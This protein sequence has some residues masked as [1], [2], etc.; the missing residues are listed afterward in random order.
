[1][2]GI[3]SDMICKVIGEFNNY[4]HSSDDTDYQR[5]LKFEDFMKGTGSSEDTEMSRVA[6]VE[7]SE[8]DRDIELE[9][10]KE[11][12]LKGDGGTSAGVSRMFR[13]MLEDY[14]PG[15]FFKWEDYAKKLSDNFYRM[16]YAQFEDLLPKILTEKLKD[17]NIDRS[18]GAIDTNPE[19]INK[20]IMDS[21]I[22]LHENPEVLK[23]GLI[24][25][26][27]R[28]E[29]EETKGVGIADAFFV[30]RIDEG[31]L[32]ERLKGEGDEDIK[33]GDTDDEVLS[34]LKDR[35]DI[36][37]KWRGIDEY[38]ILRFTL[39]DLYGS[40]EFTVKLPGEIQTIKPG[41]Y[42]FRIK[43]VINGRG[44]I[45]E[46]K[47]QHD[48]IQ[49]N[50]LGSIAED[51]LGEDQLRKFINNGIINK[52]RSFLRAQPAERLVEDYLGTFSIGGNQ[53]TSVE[54][55]SELSGYGE[56]DTE[57]GSK[58]RGKEKVRGKYDESVERE[59]EKLRAMLQR[60]ERAPEIAKHFMKMSEADGSHIAQ[61]ISSKFP[62]ISSK[63]VPSIDSILA[64]SP[65]VEMVL[66]YI[67]SPHMPITGGGKSSPWI[68]FAIDAFH[69]MALKE[70]SV[71]QGMT[72]M[73]R[74]KRKDKI[75]GMPVSDEEILGIL[76]GKE[77]VLR[78]AF[79]NLVGKIRGVITASKGAPEL[80]KFFERRET[81]Q[82]YIRGQ[83]EEAVGEFI[84]NE[85][86]SLD[87]P[88]D[89]K[90][91]EQ[92]TK[93]YIDGAVKRMSKSAG[94]SS[95]IHELMIRMSV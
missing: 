83:V 91:I 43:K 52:Y 23:D 73:I 2:R 74:S 35:E 31:T 49:G 79:N 86:L 10:S 18:E 71:R 77:T 87:N 64:T 45:I 29:D 12:K 58:A 61:V 25:A 84:K 28:R 22:Y 36:R 65:V 7:D 59:R 81:F 55:L 38:G 34:S 42:T 70:T 8:K 66:R 32:A 37:W 76:S 53:I 33:I 39:P 94:Q 72:Q 57:K 78:N 60:W 89:T 51:G 92:F 85:G 82:A 48:S 26:Y 24:R 80:K 46:F 14:L 1:M 4:K 41:E 17:F 6:F 50:A 69:K 13:D 93:K 11:K 44:A 88:E 9:K 63:G 67:M 16:A 62:S 21:L 75:G 15:G 19:T 95:F 30:P 68:H 56:D 3:A 27:R 47:D 40:R 20:V 90:K 5:Y 54:D